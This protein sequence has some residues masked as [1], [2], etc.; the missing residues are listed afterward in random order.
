M[1]LAGKPLL[2]AWCM[3]YCKGIRGDHKGCFQGYNRGSELMSVSKA[4][5]WFYMF[6]LYERSGFAG[7]NMP[8][9]DV[10]FRLHGWILLV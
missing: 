9:L 10:S 4:L 6:L 3:G 5:E 7:L 2:G 1:S 8:G